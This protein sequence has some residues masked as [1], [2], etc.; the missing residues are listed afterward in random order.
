MKCLQRF[1]WRGGMS[2]GV[3]LCGIGFSRVDS[4]K[5]VLMCLCL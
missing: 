5:D 2:C 4:D 1:D 3:P